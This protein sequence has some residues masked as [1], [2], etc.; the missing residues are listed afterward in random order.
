MK[1]LILLCLLL[2]SSYVSYSQSDR[3]LHQ[4]YP[5]LKDTT[6]VYL[7]GS[8][9]GIHYPDTFVVGVYTDTDSIVYSV[10]QD[11][12]VEYFVNPLPSTG[13]ITNIFIFSATQYIVAFTKGMQQAFKLKFT[14]LPPSEPGVRKLKTIFG[15]FNVYEDSYNLPAIELNDVIWIAW[16]R[17]VYKDRN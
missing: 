2:A 6:E 10:K 3:E 15:V 8:L 11:S 13:E 16:N 7:V 9:E 17:V 1:K 4:Q 5:S 12:I 14:E